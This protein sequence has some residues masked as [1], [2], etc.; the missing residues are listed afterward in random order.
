LIFEVKNETN[1][2]G[3][4]MQTLQDFLTLTKGIEY[5]IAIGFLLIFIVFWKFLSYT[6]HNSVK[7]SGKKETE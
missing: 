6:R 5:L 7:D 4:K 1:L 2:K 3:D